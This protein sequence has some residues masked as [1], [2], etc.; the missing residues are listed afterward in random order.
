MNR[1]DSRP[2]EPQRSP[3]DERAT[4]V[5]THVR[6][7]SVLL[8]ILLLVLAYLSLFE[9]LIGPMRRFETDA[10][11][12]FFSLVGSNSVTVAN[13]DSLLIVSGGHQPMLAYIS[14]SCSSLMGLL[15]L[16]TLAVAV[17]R[18]RRSTTLMAYLVSASV[19]FVLNLGRMIASA[20]AG[21]WFGS[22]A[23]LLFHDWVGTIWN[24]I[25]TLFG[26]LL[27]Q[28]LTSPP[29][30]RAEQDRFGRHTARRP[31]AWSRPGMG[32][33]ARTH[34]RVRA[35]SDSLLRWFIRHVLPA[36]LRERIARERES[37][38][39]DYRLGFLD[40][41]QRCSA[42]EGLTET[43]LEAHCASLLAIATYEI[44]PKVLE[45]LSQAIEHSTSPVESWR[46]AALHLWSRG[47]RVGSQRA[48]DEMKCSP[49]VQRQLGK[50]CGHRRR[51]QML[52]ATLNDRNQNTTVRV[53]LVK[54]LC[55]QG[56]A[57]HCRSLVAFVASADEVEIIEE[58]VT[59]IAKRQWEPVSTNGVAALRLWA[60]GWLLGRET[61]LD[62][63]TL[64][65]Q[66]PSPTKSQ[67]G[68][69]KEKLK[70]LAR[71]DRYPGGIGRGGPFI[72]GVTG[73][74]GP[75]GIS[76]VRAL[77]EAG[78]QV[79][80]IDSDPHAGGFKVPGVSWAVVPRFDDPTY[81][82]AMIDQAS[83]HSLRA[84]VCTVAEEYRSLAA[85]APQLDQLGCKTWLPD[86]DAVDRCI[87]KA[88]FARV[89]ESHDIAHPPTS[90]RLRGLRRIP[91][92][93]I[94]KPRRGR[95]S[96]GVVASNNLRE[97]R[98]L[99]R[100]TP[101]LIVQSRLDGDEFTADVLIDRDGQMMTCVPRWRLATRGGISVHGL[102]FD[103]PE[104]TK[105]CAQVIAA[106]GITGAANIQGMIDE[107]G[108]VSIIEVNA[109]FSGGLPLTLAAGADV[110]GA[111]LQAIL[112]PERRIAPLYF[113]PGVRMTRVFNEFIDG[114]P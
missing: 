87:D 1:L 41:D 77:V 79:L 43:G 9:L 53:E 95:G 47:W 83:S 69:G 98:S 46:V 30:E 75:A 85:V 89:M 81:S 57:Y 61:T 31:E 42:I 25:A 92:P 28:F 29:S 105:T 52:F 80:A 8:E 44:D 63:G 55:D 49:D 108:E 110:V 78:H 33:R 36:S 74:G 48:S 37:N 109:R 64:D 24:F 16:A 67:K 106:L 56:L 66:P 6:R 96:R 88:R 97:V 11:A 26:F 50:G 51:E 62:G 84:L 102:T 59:C 65:V 22:G 58:T 13:N 86:L 68:K 20:A 82:Q 104:V 76:V 112:E 71:S 7:R 10:V 103:S 101:D 93:W 113:S 12:W 38:R 5:G 35:H 17:M 100:S 14:P 40:V 15:A 91:G 34:K 94:V 60:R 21:V 27:L 4:R 3:R 111:Y 39:I 72:V 19:L 73:A 70:G 32:Y 45:T 90:E 23:M 2:G 99:M 107:E 18:R 54:R 114:A